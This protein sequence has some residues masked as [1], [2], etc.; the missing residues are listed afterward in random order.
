MNRNATQKL[1]DDHLVEGAWGDEELGLRIDQTLM[2]DATG[3]TILQELEV[4]GLER[5]ATERSIIYVDHNLIQADN[6]SADDHA[7]LRTLGRR[8]GI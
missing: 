6:K 4:L 5:A 2:H 7:F 1:I 3:P 8:L